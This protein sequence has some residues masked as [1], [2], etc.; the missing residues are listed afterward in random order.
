MAFTVVDLFVHPLM[1]A[2]LNTTANDD[3][4]GFLLLQT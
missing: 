1:S 2:N 4:L 3:M